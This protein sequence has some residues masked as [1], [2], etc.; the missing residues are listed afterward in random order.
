MPEP[1]FKPTKVRSFRIEPFGVD[2]IRIHVADTGD[3]I[4][5]TCRPEAIVERDRE[6]ERLRK[7]NE[8]LVFQLRGILKACGCH[9]C[10]D[11]CHAHFITL[12]DERFKDPVA[13][14]PNAPVNTAGVS[15]GDVESVVLT[16]KP[17]PDGKA[18][19]DHHPEAILEA[20][21]TALR[22]PRHQAGGQ[23][24]RAIASRYVRAVRRILDEGAPRPD[25]HGNIKEGGDQDDFLDGIAGFEFPPATTDA[26]DSPW[27]KENTTTDVA[28]VK[29]R[30]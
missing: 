22:D 15:P 27:V 29:S 1:L 8:Y 13:P 26:R 17:V 14:A 4:E 6:I 25:E 18:G 19:G 28:K 23:S 24:Q 21:R 30:R 20:I 3:W 10:P 16:G 2:G 5:L 11:A 9:V 12:G 7:D